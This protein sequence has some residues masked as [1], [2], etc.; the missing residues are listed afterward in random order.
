MSLPYRVYQFESNKFWRTDET[1]IPRLRPSFKLLWLDPARSRRCFSAIEHAEDGSDSLPLSADNRCFGE[2]RSLDSG[3]QG[4][5]V[6]AGGSFFP[7]GAR[8]AR[9]VILIYLSSTTV[10]VLCKPDSAATPPRAPD[11]R[12]SSRRYDQLG[13]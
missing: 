10:G 8:S 3:L 6:S 7:S 13:I 5:V 2:R 1:R 12:F 11:L 9:R 4:Q